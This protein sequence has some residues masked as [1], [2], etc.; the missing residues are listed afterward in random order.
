[1]VVLN[2]DQVDCA[3]K[4]AFFCF[5]IFEAHLS[6]MLA[7]AGNL[8]ADNC[9]VVDKIDPVVTFII[10]NLIHGDITPL[11]NSC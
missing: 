2:S 5:S 10:L 6:D 3:A 9:V 7:A 1:M 4:R 11:K 8:D